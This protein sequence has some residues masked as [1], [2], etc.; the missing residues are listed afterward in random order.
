LKAASLA[1]A[2]RIFCSI[3][4]APASVQTDHGSEFSRKTFTACL[5]SYGVEHTGYIAACS[6]QQGS[7]ERAVGL[8]K[9]QL[10]KLCSLSTYG[11]RKNWHIALPKVVASLNLSHPYKKKNFK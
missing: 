2:F 3:F 11:G 10:S 6:Q 1:A 7:A 8:L 5:A 9:I 4:P